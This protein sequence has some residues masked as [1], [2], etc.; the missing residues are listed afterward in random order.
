MADN[1][2]HDIVQNL[3]QEFADDWNSVEDLQKMSDGET[4][5]RVLQQHFPE[6]DVFSM[7]RNQVA[8]SFE[9]RYWE[10]LHAYDIDS[11]LALTAI[12]RSVFYVGS[13]DA[14]RL[15][16]QTLKITAD[17]IMGP[18][19]VRAING[20]DE[21]K[22]EKDFTQA[23]VDF[24][25]QSTTERV[26]SNENGPAIKMSGNAEVGSIS[27]SEDFTAPNRTANSTISAQQAE[28]GDIGSIKVPGSET[29][30]MKAQFNVDA[31]AKKS[32]S[33]I[34]TINDQLGYETYAQSIAKMI[35]E[36]KAEAPLTISIQ[37][38]WGQ[39]KTS[40]MRMIKNKLEHGT[41][42]KHK[43]EDE[44]TQNDNTATSGTE[45]RLSNLNQWIGEEK[46]V[47]D[48]ASAMLKVEP[49]TL[50]CVWFN[51]LYFQDSNQVW[52]GLAH[53]ILH[54]LVDQLPKRLEKERF[55]FRLRLTRINT[56]AIRRDV[57][58]LILERLLPKGLV[59]IAM[60]L[61]ILLM[62]SSK[63]LAETAVGQF[64]DKNLW[65]NTLPMFGVVLH[66]A[67]SF[68]NKNRDWA[69]DNKLAQ[70]IDEP[71][72]QGDLGM[73]HLIEHDLD[74]A[75]KLLLGKNGHL[76]VFI[77]DLDRCTPDTVNEILLA[78]N[79]FISVQHRKLYFILGMDT[80]MVAMAIETAADKQ[81][82]TYNKNRHSSKGYGWRFM[83]KFIQLPFFIPRISTEEARNFID[84]Q[85]RTKKLAKYKTEEIEKLKKQID[86]VELLPDLQKM[87]VEFK[88]EHGIEF[89]P[90]LDAIIATKMIDI[91]SEEDSET[92]R[93]LI[94]AAM[95]DLE[96]NPREMKRFLN[97]A[98]LL[99]IRID[100]NMDVSS[101][102]H[103]LR[104]VRASH[105]ILN[106]PQCLRWLQGNAQSYTLRGI[107]TDPVDNMESLFENKKLKDFE[108]WREELKKT[109]GE[110][111]SDT[112]CQPDFYTFAMRIHA[113][114]PNLKDIFAARI[115]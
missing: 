53:S 54:Q 87:V 113:D 47:T 6:A 58:K 25:G 80:H 109:W 45:T 50:P 52:A 2:A 14:V 81:A 23:F 17:G 73:L 68:L 103:M 70:Y 62:A 28:N 39:G 20:I 27:E 21:R 51:P 94:D 108:T 65:L 7:D 57:H 98:R 102:D 71:D 106:W 104:I 90:E 48:A 110:S 60:L 11:P 105:L 18:Q 75:L 95:T 79:Q 72:Y 33:D 59:G 34:W 78:I 64:L 115:F 82:E 5:L 16:Q 69:L 76:A 61:T 19:T 38:P 40:L 32:T 9:E 92:L 107:K 12:L 101:E 88:S 56:H 96:L 67:Y 83:E 49:G 66:S 8:R 91:T 26:E 89:I 3:L 86:S 15:L 24:V 114:R 37:A 44:L 43:Q 22:F 29:N 100:H 99:F 42:S 1:S 46:Q 35:V 97:V 13:R 74:R 85:L 4:K 31:I 36:N 63:L 112:I 84:D 10:E 55:W 30:N 41:E 77:D 111:V 93:K